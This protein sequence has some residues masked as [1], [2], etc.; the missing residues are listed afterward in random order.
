LKGEREHT[1]IAETMVQSNTI[2]LRESRDQS[3][4]S[5][6]DD[7][8]LSPTIGMSMSQE[9]I[10]FPKDAGEESFLEQAKA[11]EIP[12]VR[13][14]QSEADEYLEAVASTKKVTRKEYTKHPE[15]REEVRQLLEIKENYE[16]EMEKYAEQIITFK[17]TIVQ[18]RG[19]N[20]LLRD[21][22]RDFKMDNPGNVATNLEEEVKKWE[23]LYF[24]TAEMGGAR[25]ARLEEELEQLRVSAKS[26]QESA[27]NGTKQSKNLCKALK[28]TLKSAKSARKELEE[29]KQ[30]WG[31]RES[32]LK[33]MLEKAHAES[34]QENG[35]DNLLERVKYLE[36]NV[37]AKCDIIER[38]RYQTSLL[39]ERLE[40][41]HADKER[42]L[43]IV[44]SKQENGQADL[45]EKIEYLEA[46][47]R[48]KCDIVER[49]R[50]QASLLKETLEKVHAD[51][52][53]ELDIVKQKQE[54]ERAD[55]LE[56]IEYLDADVKAKSAII[57]RERNQASK[58]EARL[59]NQLRKLESAQGVFDGALT[60]FGKVLDGSL[61]LCSTQG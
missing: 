27:D 8:S 53:R 60:S 42:E 16:V 61:C 40:K 48:A 2:L 39:K 50:N 28:S 36:A 54:N 20:N 47:V 22:L 34:K 31:E 30:R 41:A 25:I 38:E 17:E 26:S 51:K 15:P 32:L 55:L 3:D 23:A 44:K 57:E 1:L 14:E 11:K 12:R 5:I 13:A 45:L 37:R 59:N 4:Q 29:C 49:E 10:D 9:E 18:M 46:D 6:D 21:R 52:E 43:E 7:D 24:E 19:E 56:K 35:Q 33:E 58:R